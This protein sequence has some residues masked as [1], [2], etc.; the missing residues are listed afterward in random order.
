MHNYQLIMYKILY[1]NT[2]EIISLCYINNNSIKSISYYYR[3]ISHI[4]Y[5]IPFKNNQSILFIKRDY[6][7]AIIFLQ[8]FYR[9]ISHITIGL[10]LI[11]T[12]EYLSKIISLYYLSR[13]IYNQYYSQY[14]YRL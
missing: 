1:K 9:I 3:I 2:T 8:D 5:R 12:I 11:S 13:E 14:F 4:Y 7:P 10:Y 6:I